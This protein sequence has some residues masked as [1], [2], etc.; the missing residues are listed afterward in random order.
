MCLY[1]FPYNKSSLALAEKGLFESRKFKFLSSLVQSLK[2]LSFW[3]LFDSTNGKDIE[4]EIYQ[5]WIR[6]VQNLSDCFRCKYCSRISLHFAIWRKTQLRGEELPCQI[7]YAVHS[8]QISSE[9]IW[10]ENLWNL[11]RSR[12]SIFTVLFTCVQ[13][14]GKYF[15]LL[16]RIWYVD[17]S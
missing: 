17:T 11:A 7:L 10:S 14:R 2:N 13:D 9:L 1:C 8:T 12:F 15:S 4:P 16:K 6:A 3:K 5:M